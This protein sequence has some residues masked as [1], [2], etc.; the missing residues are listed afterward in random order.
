MA[1]QSTIARPYAKAVFDVASEARDLDGWASALAAA[2]EIVADE[3]VRTHLRRPELDAAQRAKFVAHLCKDLP[4][5]EVLKGSAG[6]NLLELLAENDRLGVLPEIARQ[7]EVLKIEAESKVKATLISASEVDAKQAAKVAEAL[8]RK[9]GRKVDLEVV[10]DE[11]LLGGAI[12]RAEDMM[13]DG[14]VRS[15]LQRLAETLTA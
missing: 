5:T 3:A 15:R 13:I 11:T 10:V 8:E 14:S 4:G 9:L 6:L 2:G 7:F 12:V 1:D